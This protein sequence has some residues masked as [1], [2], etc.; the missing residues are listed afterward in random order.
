M[1]KSTQINYLNFNFDVSAY[2]LLGRELITDRV[3]AL[4]EIVKNSYDA[5]ADLVEVKFTDI[6]PRST[7]SKIIIKDDGLGM[8]LND[9]K[10]KWMIIGTSSKRRERTSQ[11][12]YNRKVVGKKGI[13]RFAVDL[14]GAKLTLKTKKK[15][16]NKWIVLETNW[17]QYSDLEVIQLTLPFEEEKEFFTD[18]KNS[19][20]F[21][22]GDKNE[23]GTILEIESVNDAWTEQDIKR[24]YR[25]LA[26]LVSPN[27]K[28]TKYPFNIK[29]Q[30]D[31]PEFDDVFVQ[32][33]S[34]IEFATISIELKHNKERNV[35]EILFFEK[36]ELIKK[37]VQPRI[38]GLV[39][40]YLYYFNLPAKRKFKEKF[41]I[42]IDGV[43]IYRD[44]IITTPFAE[45]EFNQEKQKDILGIDKRRYSGFFDRLNSRDLLGFLEITDEENPNIIEATN[46]QDFIDNKEWNEVRLFVIEQI[47]QIE[48]LIKYERE[49]VRVSTKLNFTRAN[50]ELK[51]IKQ[52]IASV[53]KEVS[54]EVK[55]QLQVIEIDL[56]KL[57]G[58]VNKGIRDYARLEEDSKQKENL[59]FSLVSL[60]TYA[61]MF[62][63]MTKHTIG[64]VLRDAE[65]F[66]DHFPN[67]ELNDRFKIV[68]RRIYS[69]L[70]TL[71]NGVDFMLKYAKSDNELE[72]IHLYNLIN[73]LFTNIY[74]NVLRDEH[75]DFQLEL[76]DKLILYYNRKAIED[77][78]DNLISNSIKA[79][80]SIEKKK[81]KCS[82]IIE[83]DKL[84][85]FFSDNGIGI[86]EEDRYRIFDIFFTKTAENGGAGIGLYM[87]KTR[88][89]AMEGSI[90]VIDNEFKPTGATFKIILPFKK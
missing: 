82:G 89:E 18:I 27:S 8:E 24:A 25:E 50:E 10:N 30:S 23:Q 40:F 35:Q 28:M 17:S 64:H 61:A 74:A 22:D 73:N 15:G 31:Y 75:I 20:W 29:I 71:R 1:S 16:S 60:Q 54:P 37:E 80:K 26:R 63:H 78:F 52:N 43:K 32:P 83:K 69:E 67:E 2:R 57:Q 19:Y 5:N 87:V 13:G 47:Q 84:V 9:L 33:F 68:S 21:E 48:K 7:K 53:K 79:L 65:Y 45:N 42:D 12:P 88:I 14:L 38:F 39:D 62:S 77:I 56:S 72:D 85:L 3:T 4:F 58:T 11:E 46:R 44:G 81:I 86:S 59:F 36:G 90:E 41:N 66:S 55:K 51:N 34:I 49:I 70:Q 6:N 76:S